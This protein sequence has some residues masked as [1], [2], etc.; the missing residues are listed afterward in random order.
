MELLRVGDKII[1][2]ERLISLVNKIL[3]LRSSGSTQQE[4]AKT[5]GIER[6]FIS[7]LEGLGEIRKGRKS[8][9][10]GFP[11]ANKDEVEQVAKDTGIDFVFLLNEEERLDFV[12]H[13]SGVELFN[14]LLEVIA[15]LKDYDLVIFLGSDMRVSL[16]ER[17]LDKEVVGIP[18]GA[19]PI[20]EDKYIDTEELRLMLDSLIRKKKWGVLTERSRQR[21]FRLFKEKS[22]SRSR[23]SWREV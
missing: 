17:I 9:L 4:V 19:S 3:K 15:K 2:F 8:A 23:A 6:S 18:M 21:K 11:I 10:V 1:S 7:H 12:K 20:T 13:D 16:M 5:L 22:P 14:Q